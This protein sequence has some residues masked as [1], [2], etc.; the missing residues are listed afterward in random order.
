[1][2]EH[3][4]FVEFYIACN[5]P[6]LSRGVEYIIE[7]A[8]S[9]CP[10]DELA[11]ILYEP[12]IPWFK[13]I[14]MVR[15]QA[16]VTRIIQDLLI[17]LVEL[18]VG[19]LGFNP[20]DDEID[21]DILQPDVIMKAAEPR[22]IPWMVYRS[23][24]SEIYDTFVDYQ[25]PEVMASLPFKTIWRGLQ[26]SS[27]SFESLL[28]AFR[29][30]TKT[31]NAPITAVD[32][33]LL[34]GCH[35]SH[36]MRG[37]MIY[38]GSYT[39]E[40]AI[41]KVIRKLETMLN[42]LACKL[43]VV[44]HC[45]LPEGPEALRLT[46]RWLSR[47]GLHQATFA[48]PSGNVT[49]ADE[50][51]LLL[52]AAVIRT[53]RKDRHDRWIADDTVYP[54]I[55]AMKVEVGQNFR[56]FKDCALPSKAIFA[57]VR[58]MPYGL[59]GAIEEAQSSLPGP[60]GPVQSSPMFPRRQRSTYVPPHLRQLQL[61]NSHNN[62][63]HSVDQ[64]PSTPDPQLTSST[65]ADESLAESIQRRRFVE[66]LMLN[67]TQQSMD[68]RLLID[69]V[70]GVESTSQSESVMAGLVQEEPLISF[71]EPNEESETF[72]SMDQSSITELRRVHD[73]IMQL[74]QFEHS[75]DLIWLNVGSQSQQ[76]PLEANISKAFEHGLGNT[77]L[78]SC[79]IPQAEGGPSTVWTENN[80]LE[81]QDQRLMDIYS[82]GLVRFGLIVENPREVYRTMNQKAG[83]AVVKSTKGGPSPGENQA[84]ATGERLD[85]T[86]P[87]ANAEFEAKFP[88][89]MGAPKSPKKQARRPILYSD[90]A[91]FTNSR[92]P[93]ELK[94]APNTINGQLQPVSTEVVAT[95]S[96]AGGKL[97]KEPRLDSRHEKEAYG[98]PEKSDILRDAEDQLKTMS[99]VLE[100]AP[101]YISL[102]V[103]FGRIYIK[104]M[105]P[106][107]VNDSNSAGLHYS[108][109]E[110][111]GFLN[112][113]NFPQNCV[114]FS[115]ILSTM[116]GDAELLVNIMPP[117]EPPWHL[118]K[119]EVWYDFQC[120]FP[121]HKGESFVL[122][123]NAETFKY[124]CRGPNQE[125]LAIYMHCPQRAW[126]MK[127]CGVRS[128]A[129]GGKARF[130]CFI[131]SLFENMAILVNDKN[132]VRIV[133]SGDT[134]FH[135]AVKSI[136]MRQVARYRHPK[137]TDNSLLSITMT[138]VLEERSSPSQ[139]NRG[140][141]E[142]GEERSFVSPKS[143]SNSALPHQYV[144]A[145]I[146]S[147]RLRPFLEENIQF[148]CG[149]KAT[150][151]VGY[152][153]SEGVF[154]DMLRPAF[155]MVTHMDHIGLS[156]NTMGGASDQ[157]AFH[158]ALVVSGVKKKKM[159][160][161]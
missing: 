152:L 145:S 43:K 80:P 1:M 21:A 26:N 105:A 56:P 117:G 19:G 111:V 108:V 153:E 73:E 16:L 154:E 15:Y 134:T 72:G 61:Q 151:D 81:A 71:D 99:Q 147:S 116:G 37:D 52:E 148:E 33:A 20:H 13:C 31:E 110:A 70:E 118:A 63:G 123:L 55:D 100:F 42:L 28:S 23:L 97:T 140:F 146:T 112:G 44:S 36:N 101:G 49:V 11:E 34:N 128:T 157:D 150:W 139:T 158:E 18:E 95:T 125:I 89:L 98:V 84:S 92:A 66:T 12:D 76:P 94:R 161:W 62:Q 47:I 127:A 136:H 64:Q 88:P 143:S 155:G 119:K 156:N 75:D 53:E 54:L 46:C 131:A 2:D 24:G 137:Q 29:S 102:A 129:L 142:V 3:D 45:I 113:V 74:E 83:R 7:S 59:Q 86:R 78:L 25:Y 40:A 106:S 48:V 9:A 38:V 114:G 69:W 87:I 85:H 22:L 39:S 68:E 144:E 8:K 35:I 159:E 107:L 124:R 141:R 135:T 90:A 67:P 133:F 77:C 79:D 109:S 82:D 65:D 120:K 41:E 149:D 17:K 115:P 6:L 122:E 93:Q 14:T 32:F 58:A 30:L 10:N 57:N 51:K 121:G 91:R 50:Y 96:Q 126:D 27:G 132:D 104:Q 160:F 103:V 138:H 5:P 130:K 60:H 4:A